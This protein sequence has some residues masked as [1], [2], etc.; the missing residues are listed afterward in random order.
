M[1]DT[2]GLLIGV[3]VA[4]ASVQDSVAGQALIE[5][6]PVEHPRVSPA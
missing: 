2:V 6:V 5:K 1:I 4:G 3:L